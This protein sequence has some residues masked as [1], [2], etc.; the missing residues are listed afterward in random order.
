MSTWHPQ[1]EMFPEVISD[2]H[3]NWAE[4]HEQP[5]ERTLYVWYDSTGTEVSR[6]WVGPVA[7]EETEAAGDDR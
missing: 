6:W 7:G 5:D 3:G 1:F 2:G 4:L